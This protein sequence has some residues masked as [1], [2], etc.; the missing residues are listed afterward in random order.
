MTDNDTVTVLPKLS[1]ERFKLP[2]R[3]G[4]GVNLS[5]D[6]TKAIDPDVETILKPI[7]KNLL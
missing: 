3:R 1:N 7:K 6:D 4:K 2:N 5:N